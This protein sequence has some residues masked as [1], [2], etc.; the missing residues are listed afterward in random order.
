MYRVTY[1]GTELEDFCAFMADCNKH[2]GPE[3]NVTT[4]ETP[5]RNG[6]LVLDNGSYKNYT[7]TIN[8][9]INNSPL[10]NLENLKAF[11]LASPGYRRLEDELHPDTY[12]MARFSGPFTVKSSDRNGAAF[13]LKFDCKPQRFLT[14][15]EHIRAFT[16]SGS[17]IINPTL[18]DAKPLLR[19]YGIGTLSIGDHSV[20]I[21]A[22]PGEY[23]EIDCDI[24]E[25]YCGDTNCNENITLQN[26]E[27]PVLKPGTNGVAWTG[28]ITR[29]EITPRWWKL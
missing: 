24:M 19:V 28:S 27:F 10:E 11:L 6:S 17:R 7:Y 29:V 16:S 14:S 22:M 18:F 8:A 25:A 9:Y 2:D 4:K 20:T 3:R 1:D 23:T 21:T 5:G 13:D 15:G 12:L 26:N